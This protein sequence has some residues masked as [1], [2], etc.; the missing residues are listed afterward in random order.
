MQTHWDGHRTSNT[1]K[2]VSYTYGKAGERTS[3]TYPDGKTIYY[4]F[5]EQV[6]LTELRVWRFCFTYGYDAAGRLTEKHFPNGLHTAYRYG[7][8]ALGRLN[9]VVKD[10]NALR[11]YQ[12]DAFGNRTRL[13]E[14]GKQ[15]TYAY[16][17]VNQLM[18]RVDAYVE[19]TYTY[20]KRGNLSQIAANEKVKNQYLYGALNRME[21]AVNGKGEAAKYQYNGLGHRVGKEIE[22]EN[23]QTI[24]EGLD[25][26][27]QLQSQTIRP[28]KQVQYTIDLTREYHNL[29]QKEEDNRSQTFLWDGNVAGMLEGKRGSSRY[30][31]QDELGSPV[32]LADE[33][34]N[35][36]DSY[37]YDEFGQDLYGNQGIVQPFGFTGYQKDGIIGTYFAQARE[38]NA[39]LGRFYEEDLVK[40][41]I[42]LP[43]T[44]NSYKYSLNQPLRYIDPTGLLEES[45]GKD[46]NELRIAWEKYCEQVIENVSE[47]VNWALWSIDGAFSGIEVYNQISKHIP[48]FITNSNNRNLVNISDSINYHGGRGGV[49]RISKS[50]LLSRN[51]DLGRAYRT[52]RNLNRISKGLI[53]LNAGVSFVS[54]YNSN[55]N[56]PVKEKVVNSTV[57]AT[58][59][60]GSGVAIGAAV[61]SIVPG[62][63]TIAG[64]AIGFVAGTIGSVIIDGVVRAKWFENGSKSIMDYAKQGANWAVNKVSEG[65]NSIGEAFSG[66]GDLVFG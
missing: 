51:D 3:I 41:D 13:I 11:A 57:E 42:V 19:E 34:G 37:G 6:R 47:P 36:S 64:A 20:D 33:E 49:R 10:G 12:Y 38:Y 5:D 58:W 16:N 24:N 8:D 61:G 39:L 21:Q 52:N 27:K 23:F 29:L 54:E 35:L 9:E 44:Q 18:S 66:I 2:T 7:Y 56:L 40:G 62:A 30:Y 17:N 28:E 55:P 43:K 14:R 48:R 60:V 59:S 26:I 25:P 46:E 31:L 1:Q 22:K 15:T 65:L 53:V 45:S 32:R 4:V 63:G 50:N